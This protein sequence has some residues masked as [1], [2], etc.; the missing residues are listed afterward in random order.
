MERPGVQEKLET[1][2]VI[3]TDRTNLSSPMH[4][5]MP[6]ILQPKDYDRWLTPGDPER[7]PVDLLRPFPAEQMKA[8]RW[9]VRWAT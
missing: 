6:V 2:T 4:N 1:F 9:T 5:R 3:T 8:W 7:L